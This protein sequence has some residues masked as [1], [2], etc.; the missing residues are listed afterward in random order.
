MVNKVNKEN[1]EDIRFKRKR[2][3]GRNLW[4]AAAIG[5]IAWSAVEVVSP[6][7]AR[8]EE[9]HRREEYVRLRGKCL[10]VIKYYSREA[11][12][13]GRLGESV[14]QMRESSTYQACVDNLGEPGDE[15]VSRFAVL[16]EAF[17][18]P[19]NIDSN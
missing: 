12:V 9:E 2:A 14:A 16:R 8:I 5:L 1:M 7:P 10:A 17:G 3:K 15:D 4:A 6:D 11:E 18:E 19:A 13:T